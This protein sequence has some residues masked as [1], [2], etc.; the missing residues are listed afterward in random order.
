MTAAKRDMFITRLNRTLFV[1]LLVMLAKPAGYLLPCRNA[2]SLFFFFPFFHV[3][4]AEKVHA[5]IVNCVAELRPWVFFTKRSE[6][7]KFRSLYSSTARLFNI[8]PLL[9]YAYPLSAGIMAGFINRHENPV[10]FGS[11]SLFYYLL[12]PHLKPAVRCV[13]LLHAFGGG[14]EHFSLPVVERLD[15]RVI[16]NEQILAELKTL[17]GANGIDPSLLKKTV[18]VE[19][20]VQIP[21][22]LP[23]KDEGRSLRVLYVGRSGVEKRVHLVGRVARLCR[24]RRIAAQFMLAGDTEA[25]VDAPD[26]GACIFLGE[27]SDPV[28]LHR[29]YAEADL[30]LLTSSREGFPLVVMEAMAHGVVPICTNVGGISRHVCHGINGFLVA[31]NNEEQIVNDVVATIRALSQD[32]KWLGTLSGKT[33]EHARTCFSP[34][35]FR[36]TYRTILQPGHTGSAR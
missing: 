16:I 12:A 28:A 36:S 7:K 32:R 17:Y 21:D 6:N 13:D 11:N 26:R 18:L 3:G 19:N 31:N 33:F 29:L 2:S 8:W 23:I 27:I 24:E 25:A 10:V 14:A 35:R 9:K 22:R 15:C 5:D 1:R 34:T 4:G 20:M 30:L